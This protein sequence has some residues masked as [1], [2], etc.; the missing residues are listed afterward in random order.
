MSFCFLTILTI[1]LRFLS[2]GNEPPKT[3]R[4]TVNV[5]NTYIH[6]LVCTHAVVQC[7]F[8]LLGEGGSLGQ[9]L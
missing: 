1:L 6:A 3:T 4:D 5:S 7:S 8:M 2:P 9:S